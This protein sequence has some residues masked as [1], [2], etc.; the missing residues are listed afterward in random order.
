MMAAEV[1]HEVRDW[2]QA[3]GHRVPARVRDSWSRVVALM[4]LS[5]DACAESARISVSMK[6]REVG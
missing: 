2:R 3:V 6:V 4:I 5:L 1:S